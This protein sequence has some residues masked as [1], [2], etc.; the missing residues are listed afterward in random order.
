MLPSADGR[1][2]I[3]PIYIALHTSFL[4]LF[5]FLI[6]LVF[7]SHSEPVERKS[8]DLDT[9]AN[10]LAMASARAALRNRLPCRRAVSLYV[11][12]TKTPV[13]SALQVSEE[14]QEALHG[15]RK[16]PVVALETTIYT[17]G[18]LASLL[19]YATS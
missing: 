18:M 15:A 1:I 14:V 19:Q 5:F 7:N 8:L 12:P 11:K 6:S 17:H 3:F 2:F 16:R 9:I 10:M 13:S 4:V